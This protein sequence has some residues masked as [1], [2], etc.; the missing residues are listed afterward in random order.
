VGVEFLSIANRLFLASGMEKRSNQR[1][2]L[3]RAMSDLVQGP[4]VCFS[5]EEAGAI[6]ERCRE[7]NKAVADLYFGGRWPLFEQSADKNNGRQYGSA[8]KEE[9]VELSLK[10][11]DSLSRKKV[12]KRLPKRARVGAGH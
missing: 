2:R 4:K 12:R 3:V 1:V 11:I 5:S 7:S 8:T 10:L 9:F 6:R